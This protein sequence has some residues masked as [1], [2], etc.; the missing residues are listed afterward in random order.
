[1]GVNSWHP[2]NS[3]HLWKDVDLRPPLLVLTTVHSA[4]L[5]LVLQ[6]RSTD[7]EK[8]C[9]LV[10]P[11]VA[12]PIPCYDINYCIFPYVPCMRDLKPS[13]IHSSLETRST[14]PYKAMFNLRSFFEVFYTI[15]FSSPTAH[16]V[17]LFLEESH[18]FLLF[19][20][21]LSALTLLKKPSRHK[22]V[23]SI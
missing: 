23:L 20:N 21:V 1:M 22:T 2:M 9:S 11:P 7:R 4:T 17:E 14:N 13:F 15:Y 18:T 12:G 10:F 16:F 19:H 5:H 6:F 3:W 8:L